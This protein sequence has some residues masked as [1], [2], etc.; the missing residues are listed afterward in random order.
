[1]ALFEI[2]HF[3]SNSLAGGTNAFFN[4]MVIAMVP[5]FRRGRHRRQSEAIVEEG[6]GP[7][8]KMVKEALGRIS[9]Q[10]AKR[11]GE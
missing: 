1:M 11:R 2:A 7:D 6:M 10:G 4:I 8:D 9:K 5:S 3:W